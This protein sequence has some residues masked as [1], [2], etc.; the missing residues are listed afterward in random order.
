MSDDF[1]FVLCWEP[2]AGPTALFRHQPPKLLGYTVIN[3]IKA[4]IKP[5][6]QVLFLPLALLR[7][8]ADSHW[9]T[10][11]KIVYFAVFVHIAHAR[12]AF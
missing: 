8:K 12:T 3:E 5:S 7:R 4:R 10:S 9:L 6:A 1:A 2:F 11:S